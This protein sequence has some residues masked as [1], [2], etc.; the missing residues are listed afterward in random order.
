MVALLVALVLGTVP[1]S[2][3]VQRARPPC[4]A[5][6]HPAREIAYTTDMMKATFTFAERCMT[7][8]APFHNVS[9]FL[10]RRDGDRWPPVVAKG[11]SCDAGKPCRVVVRYEHPPVEAETYRFFATFSDRRGRA[12]K[13]WVGPLDCRSLAVVASCE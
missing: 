4:G 10:L 6:H 13:V 12:T 7:K 5:K 8:G 3:A 9:V 2:G 11:K 1:A